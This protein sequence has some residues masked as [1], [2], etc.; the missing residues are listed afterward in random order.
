MSTRTNRLE[1]AFVRVNAGQS[2]QTDLPLTVLRSYEDWASVP[3]K[4]VQSGW[5]QAVFLDAGY[6]VSTLYVWPAPSSQYEIHLLLLNPLIRIND[7]S[8]D[9]NLPDEYLDAIMWNLG[10]RL[11]SSYR[12]PKDP[13]I[14][15]QA[16]AALNTVRNAN[17]QLPRLQIP[18]ELTGFWGYNIYTDNY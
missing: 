14:E 9:L 12:K 3:I 18:R 16:A 5:P 10:K 17:I 13:E 7:L 4:N 2:S 15:Q 1:K 6:P 11:L 8:T